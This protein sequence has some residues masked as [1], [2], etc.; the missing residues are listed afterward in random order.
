MIYLS[1]EYGNKHLII[2]DV[3]GTLYQTHSVSAPDMQKALVEVELQVSDADVIQSYFGDRS[4]VFCG[5]IA[6]GVFGHSFLK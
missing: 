1:G 5:K 3:D 4:D 6:S 2:F